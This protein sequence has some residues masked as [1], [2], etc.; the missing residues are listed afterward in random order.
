MATVVSDSK[1]TSGGPWYFAGQQNGVNTWTT[2][3]SPP[4]S[5]E[6]D[7]GGSGDSGGYGG[8]GGSSGGSSGSAGAG[9]STYLQEYR[10]KFHSKG[11]PPKDLLKQA[12]NGN[13]SLAYFDQMVR[14][15]DPEYLGSKEAKSLLLG[16][17]GLNQTMKILFPGLADASKQKALLQSPFYK[18]IATWYLR[19]GIGL[20][21]NGE[22][23]LYERVTGTKKW[24]QNNPYW[25]LYAKNRNA[26][27]QAEANPLAYK[28]HVEALQNAFKDVGMQMPDDYYTSFF[29]SRYA[30]SS[31]FSGFTDNLK[32]LSQQGG[33]YNWFEGHGTTNNENKQ[34]LFGQG[35][36]QADLKSRLS[37]HFNVQSSFL[38]KDQEGFGTEQNKQG[39]LI[40]STL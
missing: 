1:P 38:S 17:G 37:Q 24:N 39:K 9:M 30:S 21:Q 2:S 27:V 32:Q 8:S 12:T 10:I 25:K 11:S 26:S 19:N 14:S 40:K 15:K 23:I 22:A 29:K 20:Q 5:T 18:R 16:D 7:S 36:P 4:A 3:K 33:A 6:G 28:A 31:G 34:V 13:W 35:K